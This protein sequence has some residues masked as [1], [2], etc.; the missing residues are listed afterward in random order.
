MEVP[1]EGGESYAAADEAE[2]VAEHQGAG[3]GEESDEVYCNGIM[4]SI[5]YYEP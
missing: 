1:M 4:I 5:D 3:A 2:I